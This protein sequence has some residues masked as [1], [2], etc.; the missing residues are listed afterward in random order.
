MHKVALDTFTRYHVNWV[1]KL[2]N[3]NVQLSQNKEVF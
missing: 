2:L 3:I 1:S